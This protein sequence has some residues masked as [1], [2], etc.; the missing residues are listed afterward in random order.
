VAAFIFD[1]DGVLTDTVEYHY[2]SWR[3]L[4]MEL[5]IP[6]TRED[7]Q[8]LL[9]RSRPDSLKIFLQGRPVAE[10]EFQ[11]LLVKK[12][13]YFLD[14]IQ[15]FSPADL[16]P[17]VKTLLTAIKQAGFKMAVASSSRN[18]EF[19]LSRLGIIAS[20]DSISDS[21][22][23]SRAKPAPDLFLD[24]ANRLKAAP[25]AC[26][27]F[28]DSTAGV[29]AGVAAGMLVVGI[30]PKELVEQAHLR[31]QSMAKVNLEEILAYRL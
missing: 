11:Q 29:A 30:G 19:I 21:N 25:E 13:E 1:M 28:E 17:G 14:L 15:H 22:R 8:K 27:V 3:Q 18:T 10:G 4:A 5:K 16:L 9:G 12:N 26:V 24:A 23:I 31:Y 7:N 6:F 20:F 2:Q